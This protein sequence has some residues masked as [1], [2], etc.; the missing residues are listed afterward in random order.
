MEEERGQGENRGERGTGKEILTSGIIHPHTTAPSSSASPSH[1]QM[2]K[3]Y[4][5]SNI[6]QGSLRLRIPIEN[7]GGRV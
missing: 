6:S 1:V 4:Q 7:E 5:H 3:I 2:V